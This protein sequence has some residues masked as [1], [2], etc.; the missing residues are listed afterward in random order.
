M[1]E[2]TGPEK[3]LGKTEMD[4]NMDEIF[5]SSIKLK[6]IILSH[7]KPMQDCPINV[8]RAKTAP[9]KLSASWTNQMKSY[10]SAE[11]LKGPSKSST[12]LRRTD[13]T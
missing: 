9:E 11:V 13:Q 12:T 8:H 4:I 1:L 10:F 5:N 6:I 2:N 7:P 3:K